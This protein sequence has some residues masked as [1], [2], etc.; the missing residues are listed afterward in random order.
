MLISTET[1]VVKKESIS[2]VGRKTTLV[3]K[4]IITLAISKKNH[5]SEKETHFFG[6]WYK[7][8]HGEKKRP[9]FGGDL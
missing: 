6:D 5:R 4:E 2:V 7:N 8:H 3:K 1:T 9:H